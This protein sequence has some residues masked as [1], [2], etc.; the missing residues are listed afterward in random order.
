MAKVRDP[1]DQINQLY[2]DPAHSA[3]A[4]GLRYVSDT[5]P[6]WGRRRCGKGW[7]FTD[8][9]GRRLADPALKQRALQLAIP[10]AWQQVWISPEPDAH[11]QATGFDEA[12]RK[13]YLYHP[14]WQRFR[15]RLKF[16][17]MLPFS[18]VLPR[19]RAQA[20]QALSKSETPCR[21]NVL[22]TMLLLLDKGALRIGSEVYLEANES[23]GLTT[24]HPQHLELEGETV[25]LRYTGK[26]GQN[27]EICL[28]DA[29]LSRM[30]SCL[31]AL[32]GERLFCY[33]NADQTLCHLS[34]DELNAY[35]RAVSTHPIS[36]K[37]FRTW[38][39]TLLAFEAL[40]QASDAG[41]TPTL[42]AIVE[43]VAQTLGNT[44]AVAQ[45]SY[46]H[47]DLLDLWREERFAQAYAPLQKLRGRRYFS[48]REQQLQSLLAHLLQER[49]E[50]PAEHMAA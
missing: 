49:F 37:D 15:N 46:I 6:G 14:D 27:Q 47:P 32:G 43:Q 28:K 33:S 12:G 19:L 11:L 25:W 2:T 44:P 5:E 50:L 18:E 35:L 41:K 9:R 16:Y 24:L 45:S 48:R 29:Q 26:H 34:A 3:R 20:W 4:V 8:T 17:H 21:E 22:A 30:L 38:K 36:A 23:V 39:G 7:L 10:P 31:Q 42:K 13:Q 1:F 40:A